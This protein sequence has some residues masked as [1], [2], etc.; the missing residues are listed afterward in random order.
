MDQKPGPIKMAA[1]ALP[2]S[3]FLDTGWEKTG[4]MFDPFNSQKTL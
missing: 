2:P 3:M 4:M 1:F